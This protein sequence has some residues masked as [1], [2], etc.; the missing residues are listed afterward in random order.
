MILL[1]ESIE[2]GYKNFL[3]EAFIIE[4]LRGLVAE[5][6]LAFKSKITELLGSRWQSL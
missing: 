6:T 1:C 4:D 3:T 2:K 5:A